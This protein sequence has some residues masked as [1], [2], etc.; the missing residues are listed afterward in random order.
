M[1]YVVRKTSAAVPASM[2]ITKLSPGEAKAIPLRI[3]RQE[4]EV[5]AARGESRIPLSKQAREDV[6]YLAAENAAE[7]RA[8]GFAGAR[9]GGLSTEDALDEANEAW[10]RK[11]RG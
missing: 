7:A 3:L 1:G 10:T 6:E 2:T 5:A 8:E 4:M 11:R 9:A